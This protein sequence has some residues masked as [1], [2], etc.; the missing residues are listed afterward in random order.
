MNGFVGD[1]SLIMIV[2]LFS[3]CRTNPMS[4]RANGRSAFQ[5]RCVYADA[6]DFDLKQLVFLTV[7]Q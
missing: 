4:G 5:G 1:L 7:I 2:L 6:V 3:E